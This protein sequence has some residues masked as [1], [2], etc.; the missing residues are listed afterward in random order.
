M[1][2]QAPSSSTSF[3]QAAGDSRLMQ[4]G[5][6]QL[7]GQ[8]RQARA[9][10]F[11]GSWR[12]LL[13][14][15]VL[16]LGCGPVAWGQKQGGVVR[17]KQFY[18]TKP[19]ASLL[20]RV[21]FFMRQCD[22][23]LHAARQMWQKVGIEV[24]REGLPEVRYDDGILTPSS[25]HL[26]ARAQSLSGIV[27]VVHIDTF[28]STMID[29]LLEGLHTESF[30]NTHPEI[31]GGEGRASIVMLNRDAANA[32]GSI[33][34]PEQLA[35]ARDT[36][37]HE[38]GHVLLDEAVFPSHLL[39]GSDNP[40]H[41]KDKEALMGSGLSMLETRDGII[42]FLPMTRNSKYLNQVEAMYTASS[43]V[44]AKT[45]GVSSLFSVGL[46]FR[47]ERDAMDP[48]DD[49]RFTGS[50]AN[51]SPPPSLPLPGQFGSRVAGPPAVGNTE[52]R[53]IYDGQVLVSNPSVPFAMSLH[54]RLV[55]DGNGN[56]EREGVFEFI[57]IPE[58][59]T[60]TG[61]LAIPEGFVDPLTSSTT[62]IRINVGG[63]GPAKQVKVEKVSASG[64]ITPLVQGAQY[65]LVISQGAVELRHVSPEFLTDGSVALRVRVTTN[66][67]P[68]TNT[69]STVRGDFNADGQ[70]SQADVLLLYARMGQASTTHD[71]NGD[72]YVSL[73][74]AL[75][76]FD[77]IPGALLADLDFDGD[78]DSADLAALNSGWGSAAARSG[79]DIDG[80]GLVTEV[81]LTLMAEHWQGPPTVSHGILLARPEDRIATPSSHVS[82]PAWNVEWIATSGVAYQIESSENLSDWSPLG[83]Q[84]SGAGRRTYGWLEMPA[85]NNR[86]FIRLRGQDAPA[87]QFMAV[88]M[89]FAERVNWQ[90]A[91]GDVFIIQNWVPEDALSTV[92][93]WFS[94]AAVQ[95]VSA[96]TQS[97]V[98]PAVDDFGHGRRFRVLR[99]APANQGTSSDFAEN[100]AAQWGTFASDNAAASVADSTVRT[101]DGAASLLFTTASG[102]DTG[103][104]YPATPSM[105]F[106]ASAYN[107]L[108]WW[109]YP[110]NTTPTGWQDAQ[111]VVVLHT[112]G[113][114]I[115]LRPDAQLT[116][117][118]AWQR[119][120]VP[121]AGGTGWTREVTG[122][123][124]LRHVTQIEIHHDTWESGF[125][126]WL[127]GVRFDGGLFD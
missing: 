44:T 94:L 104:K 62:G 48:N 23:D 20:T 15:A 21:A 61:K 19:D 31:E 108:T 81:D 71:L 80:D 65:E 121:L 25:A 29:A 112:L 90:A 7:P 53:R 32:Y 67:P 2:G 11:H 66:P 78:V 13:A 64:V 111:P 4:S 49:E 95:S 63:P 26:W 85:L 98:V 45:L 91:A 100:N 109:A 57:V 76:I 5:E 43:Y 88:P 35:L 24:R 124:D 33:T 116:G 47:H 89:F 54:E 105:D 114:A 96:G 6:A 125:R 14:L 40:H 56:E 117:Y 3:G 120:V 82:V 99:V 9:G 118:S 107:T 102:F 39:I 37:A 68:A 16:T 69:T 106:D 83:P 1:S 123:P 126:I 52:I 60:P 110:E 28:G 55:D 86:G 127:D 113:G 75:E 73:G 84:I 79:G 22:Q 101:K 10:G 41:L 36:F 119:F 72:G 42:D 122:S 93:G 59:H 74:D 27:P 115:T 87:R 58:D 34:D 77:L 17:I 51:F 103:V 97:A 18:L 50:F 12:L 92:G 70:V 30:G 8:G 38:I 46:D